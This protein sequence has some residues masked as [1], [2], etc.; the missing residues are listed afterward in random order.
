MTACEQTR[1]KTTWLMLGRVVLRVL[2]EAYKHTC[3]WY[4][5]SRFGDNKCRRD[6]GDCL[7]GVIRGGARKIVPSQAAKY[8]SER[9]MRR[10][11]F[12][13]KKNYSN[14][15]QEQELQVHGGNVL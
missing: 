5:D 7:L 15:S 6:S 13:H 9:T 11:V 8:V 1:K 3:W 10:H 12:L 14:A 2:E 4:D